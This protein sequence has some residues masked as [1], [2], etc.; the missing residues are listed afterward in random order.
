MQL[1]N[2]K[3]LIENFKFHQVEG[4]EMKRNCVQLYCQVELH[5]NLDKETN[6]QKNSE[7]VVFNSVHI[8]T[9]NPL[10]TARVFLNTVIIFCSAVELYLL[11]KKY[12]LKQNEFPVTCNFV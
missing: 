10:K 5:K 7:T 6:K 3:T 9:W 12:C 4:S 1:E 2:N 11:R 8:S